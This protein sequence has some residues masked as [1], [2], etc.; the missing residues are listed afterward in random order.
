[1][2]RINTFLAAAL[3]TAIPSLSEAGPP[4]LCHPFQTAN[5]PLLP[6]G[7]GPG[8]NTPS[9]SYDVRRLPD[10]VLRLL[11]TDAPVLARME[12][13]RRAV[14]YAWENP[15]LADQLIAALAARTT[16]TTGREQALALFDAGYIL[17]TY[18]QGAHR[19]HRTDIQD[20]YS[21]VLR[22]IT[23]TGGNS[24]MEFAASLMTEGERAQSHVRRARAAAS[25]GSLLAKNIDTLWR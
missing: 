2:T 4:L 15:R 1:M 22:A 5:S 20:G 12:N 18:Q 13:M 25:A 23:M 17:E 14:I 6:W 10:D 21:M 3:L 16:S 8:W 19:H 11:S 9:D 24:E 7:S